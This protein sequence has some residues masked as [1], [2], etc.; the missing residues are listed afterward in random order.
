MTTAATKTAAARK[1]RAKAAVPGDLAVPP[2]DVPSFDPGDGTAQALDS[3]DRIPLF[4]VG[5]VT[6]TMPRKLTAGEGI[7][8]MR[9]IR[10]TNLHAAY[11][12]ELDRLVGAEGVDALVN[13]DGFDQERWNQIIHAMTTHVFGAVERAPKD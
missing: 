2:D 5:K 9:R 4:R 3:A 11:E 10:Q 13:S 7:R 12:E 8:L 1:S 6:Y